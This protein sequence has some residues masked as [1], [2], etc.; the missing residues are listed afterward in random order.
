MVDVAYNSGEQSF[1]ASK[2]RLFGE[3]AASRKILNATHPDTIKQL[4]RH[5]R[6]LD[7]T[8]WVR[9]RESIMLTYVYYKFLQNP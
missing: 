4:G 2:A 1:A 9:E 6:G 3:K 7:E 8:V 5:V